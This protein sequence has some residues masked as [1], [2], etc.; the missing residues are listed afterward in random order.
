VKLAFSSPVLGSPVGWNE[1][2]AS[3]AREHARRMAKAGRR[4]H[5]Y[6]DRGVFDLLSRDGP[7]GSGASGPPGGWARLTVERPFER[8]A[9]QVPGPRV[10]NHVVTHVLAEDSL[11]F[12]FT[13]YF[14]RE[15]AFRICAAD[16]YCVEVAVGCARAPAPPPRKDALGNPW[17]MPRSPLVYYCVSFVQVNDKTIV[18]G[19]D[20]AY[21]DL[22]RAARDDDPETIRALGVWGR[23]ASLRPVVRAL[24]DKR[25]EVVAAAFDA[26]LLLDEDDAR[27]RLAKAAAAR[28]A[29]RKREKWDEL[30]DDLAWA[31][32]VTYDERIAADARKEIADTE[33]KRGS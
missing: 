32:R 6:G 19:L 5:S 1:G 14:E 28:A 26:L 22:V 24:R 27:A 30:L 9:V 13:T 25:P 20:D 17:V 10:Q 33:A 21:D 29:L 15:A 4:Q 12:L 31:A 18:R 2:V 23:E 3:R 11:E 8:P 7:A 16:P